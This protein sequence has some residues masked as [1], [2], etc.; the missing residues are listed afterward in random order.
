MLPGYRSDFQRIDPAFIERL[1]NF[2]FGHAVNEA[3]QACPGKTRR[4]AVLAALL[5]WQG[6]DEFEKLLPAALHFGV[7]P[8]EAEEAI[9]QAVAYLDLGRVYPFLMTTNKV[10]TATGVPLPLERSGDH[11]A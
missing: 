11:D 7:T 10:F 3:G 6:V 9:Y 5:G 8:V 2:A 1:D 4:L